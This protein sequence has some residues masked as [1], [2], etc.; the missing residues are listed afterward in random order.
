MKRHINFGSIEQFRNTIKGVT[1]RARY[2]GSDADYKPIYDKHIKLPTITFTASEKIHGTNAAV[3]FTTTEGFWVQS[4]SNIITP[5]KDNAGCAA[6]AYKDESEWMQIITD[7]S[8][9]HGLDQDNNI[10]TVY[11]EWC[12]GSIQKK[13]AVS[14]LE[15]RAIIFQHFKVSP[16]VPTPADD[17]N[18]EDVTATW[19]ETFAND[20]ICVNDNE[21]GIFNIMDFPFSQFTVDFEKPLF[22]QNEMIEKVAEIEANSPVGKQFGVDGNVGEGIVC[23]AMYKDNLYR[24]K[25]KG[26]KHSASK[27]KTLKPVDEAAEQIKIDFVNNIA[28][29]SSRLEQAWQ[30]TFGIENEKMLPDVSMTGDFLR[31]VIVDVMKEESDIMEE[32]ELDPKKINGAISKVARGWFMEQLDKEAGI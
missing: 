24:F 9:E 28:C 8:M 19:H 29:T 32:N 14:S 16:L 11:F 20:G 25:V 31:A 6:W 12:G 27:V 21:A 17:P 26:E 13:S 4:R 2:I 22:S 3:S 5:E 23:T 7:L 10:I 30:N 1:H 15:K 18:A